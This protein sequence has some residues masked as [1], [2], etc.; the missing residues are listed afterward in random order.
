M[1]TE[2]RRPRKAWRALQPKDKAV[3]SDQ[4]RGIALKDLVD[5]DVWSLLREAKDAYLR[6]FDRTP[7]KN[8]MN[9]LGYLTASL[10]SDVLED[11]FKFVERAAQEAPDPADLRE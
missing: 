3:T 9:L 5:S 11:F 8:I 6:D 2:H 10:T 4:R 1:E 7:P